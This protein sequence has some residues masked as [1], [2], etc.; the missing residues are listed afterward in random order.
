[1]EIL[2]F[3]FVDLGAAPAD[4][5]EPGDSFRNEFDADVMGVGPSAKLAMRNAL[6]QLALEGYDTRLL[7]ESSIEAGWSGPDAEESAANLYQPAEQEDMSGVVIEYH[8]LIRF[9]DP[10]IPDEE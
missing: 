1:M 10:N 6:D 5:V 3:E 4:T 8:V 9:M 2:R 7:H